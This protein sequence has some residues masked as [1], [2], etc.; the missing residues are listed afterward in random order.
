MLVF[1]LSLISEDKRAV[2]N[3]L[4]CF[5][6]GFIAF[7]LLVPI[8]YTST[9]YWVRRLGYMRWLRLHQLEEFLNEKNGNLHHQFRVCDRVDER[10]R[11]D[12][13]TTNGSG[14]SK[15]SAATSRA[16]RSNGYSRNWIE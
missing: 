1:G 9:N 7:L 10:A 2:F 3:Y 6:F 5:A 12:S 13:H 4:P 16:R 15:P 14:T 8:A 11:A